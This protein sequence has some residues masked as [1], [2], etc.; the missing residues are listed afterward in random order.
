MICFAICDVLSI[1]SI[2]II[3]FMFCMVNTQT[4]TRSSPLLFDSFFILIFILILNHPTSPD[5]PFFC[6][7]PFKIRTCTLLTLVIFVFLLHHSLSFNVLYCRIELKIE[8]TCWLS[9]AFCCPVL[10]CLY[11]MEWIQDLLTVRTN[12]LIIEILFLPTLLF[13][14]A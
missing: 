4:H 2:S 7:R 5:P 1:R 3:I 12:Y 6:V 14:S 8:F 13:F 11:G 10:Y 9:C